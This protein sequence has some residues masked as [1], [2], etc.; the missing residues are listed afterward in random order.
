[1]GA[2][3]GARTCARRWRRHSASR[4]HAV[5]RGGSWLRPRAACC[6]CPW[7]W[8]RRPGSTRR[9]RAGSPSLRRSWARWRRSRAASTRVRRRSG[10]SWKRATR[11]C[12]RVVP[13]H[14]C[15]DRRSRF[16]W[17]RSR[18]RWSIAPARS[19]SA[20]PSSRRGSTCPP[21][22]RP[23][24]APSR[25]QP[26]CATRGQR[27]DAVRS[28]EAEYEQ[29]IRGWI[30]DAVRWQEEPRPRRAGAW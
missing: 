18:P 8:R 4:W 23:R 12:G 17:P 11:P 5:A 9:S 10:Q 19:Q 16:A 7:T 29:A 20:A 6:T 1:M 15:T 13:V 26:R 14:A 24:S 21:F 27:S 25:K 28:A 30:A 2:T 3:S 22:L